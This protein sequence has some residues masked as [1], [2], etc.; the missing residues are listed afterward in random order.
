MKKNNSLLKAGIVL[1]VYLPLLLRI[2]PEKL[3]AANADLQLAS[4]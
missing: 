2:W 4:T 1:I 3:A